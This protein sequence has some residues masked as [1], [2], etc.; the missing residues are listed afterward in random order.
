MIKK[1][2][3]T[4]I[5][6][7]LVII[8]E[9]A[10]HHITNPTLQEEA[11]LFGLTKAPK[12]KV[13]L[14]RN[15]VAGKPSDKRKA[16]IRLFELELIESTSISANDRLKRLSLTHAGECRVIE[17]ERRNEKRKYRR[18]NHIPDEEQ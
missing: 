2:I 11:I 8:K 3:F 4:L 16:Y 6:E 14:N 9:N 15:Y 7:T 10:K 5:L 17:M 12:T 18:E 13:D 1:K